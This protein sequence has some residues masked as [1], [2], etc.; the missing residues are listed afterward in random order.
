M[1]PIA[2]IPEIISTLQIDRDKVIY[3]YW[4]LKSEINRQRKFN[5]LNDYVDFNSCFGM[6][7]LI[8]LF[9]TSEAID[10][11]IKNGSEIKRKL[12]IEEMMDFS[13]KLKLLTLLKLHPGNFLE[14]K[15]MYSKIKPCKN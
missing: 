13:D 6:D 1:K 5:L 10:F 12:T 9:I 2:T 4:K 15:K 11:L 14:F 7:Y 3:E 8:P